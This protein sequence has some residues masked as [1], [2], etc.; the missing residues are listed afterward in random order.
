MFKKDSINT[1]GCP[2]NSSDTS[3]FLDGSLEVLWKFLGS[4]VHG[5]KNIFHIEKMDDLRGYHGVPGY[6][7]T[8][9]V[10]TVSYPAWP[11]APLASPIPNRSGA[12]IVALR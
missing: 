8:W 1:H 5:K 3:K 6:Q 4:S 11:L 9:Q 12:Q 10:M 2:S 7:V